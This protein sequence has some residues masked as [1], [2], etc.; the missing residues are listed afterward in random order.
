MSKRQVL[1]LL[2]VAPAA[3]GFGRG[4]SDAPFVLGEPGLA[5]DV[6]AT[7]HGFEAAIPL[8]L[9]GAVVAAIWW[10]VFGKRGER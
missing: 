7:V 9:A 6:R 1:L 4:V 10:G 2:V 8:A 3:Y 5:F